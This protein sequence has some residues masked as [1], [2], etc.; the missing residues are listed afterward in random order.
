MAKIRCPRARRAKFPV[1]D[2][3]AGRRKPLPVDD[4]DEQQKQQWNNQCTECEAH[5]HRSTPRASDSSGTVPFPWAMTVPRER[6]ESGSFQENVCKNSTPIRRSGNHPG[7][8]FPAK[9]TGGRL[10]ATPRKRASLSDASLMHRPFGPEN[11]DL[12]VHVQGLV[13]DVVARVHHA[14][15]AA[16]ARRP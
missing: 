1:K 10:W 15:M 7:V 6:L 14:R 5:G 11:V 4:G 13:D 9:T 12:P 16:V 2:P 8:E 3:P